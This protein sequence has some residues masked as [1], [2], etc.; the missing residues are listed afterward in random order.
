MG[1]TLPA[2]WQWRQPPATTGSLLE[3]VASARGLVGED[4]TTFLEPSFYHSWTDPKLIS[5]CQRAVTRLKRS[6]IRQESL[7]IFGD[8]DADGI[9][10]TTVAVRALRQLG[11][12]QVAAII[13]TRR[14]GYGL[15][16]QRV[17]E[18]INRRPDLVLTV[19]TGTSSATEIATLTAAGIDVIVTDH[20]E[21]P[22]DVPNVTIVNPKMT[23]SGT[24]NRDLSGTAVIYKVMWALFEAV[25]HDLTPLKRMLDLVALATMADLMPLNEENRALVIY[26]LKV[27]RRTRWVGLRALLLTG[28]I[29]P[30]DVEYRHL[31]FFLAP[32]LNAISRLG[33]DES[34]QDETWGSLALALLL[35]DSPTR[36]D[37][38]AKRLHEINESRKVSVADWQLALERLHPM[39]G[40]PVTVYLPDVP[41]GLLGLLAGSVVDRWHVPALVMSLDADGTVRGSG[42]SLAGYPPLP[43]LL[44]SMGDLLLRF[45]GHNEAAGWSLEAERVDDFIAAVQERLLPTKQGK[46]P[47][48]VLDARLQTGEGSLD[49]IHQLSKLAPFGQ[50]NTE[51]VLLAVGQIESCRPLGSSGAHIRFKLA[52]FSHLPFLWFSH[53][54]IRLPAVGDTLTVAGHLSINT[55]RDPEPQFVITRASW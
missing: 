12:K 55:Y 46:P 50:G 51:P 13:P 22:A 16:R 32:R 27:M 17:R 5:G 18:I 52:D 1:V 35:A 36:A 8:Y 43:E 41:V 28:N 24:L 6:L 29:N 47:Q 38:L 10:A 26:G 20:H 37:E 33:L 34:E 48:V 23:K 40:H 3:R 49:D 7:L 53:G 14:E 30:A 2:S 9:P 45:G 21:P 15:S 54:Q 11:F 44:A 42:R 4:L 39:I 19:D 31:S 25:E